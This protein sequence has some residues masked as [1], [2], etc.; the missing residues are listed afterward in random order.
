MGPTT[1]EKAA[2]LDTPL[3]TMKCKLFSDIVTEH[4]CL[5]RKKELNAK[6]DFSC[7]GCPMD[8]AMQQQLQIMKEVLGIGRDS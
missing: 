2:K 6:G 1:R 5:L 4:L 3:S 8:A 7:I